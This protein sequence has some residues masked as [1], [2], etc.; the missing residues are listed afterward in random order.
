[1]AKAAAAPSK[2]Q[3][4]K[5]N[6]LTN[7]DQIISMAEK[8][9]LNLPPAAALMELESHG[10]NVYGNDTGGALAGFPGAVNKGNFEVYEWMV[11]DLGHPANGVGPSQITSL[12]LLTEMEEEGLRPYNVADNMLFGFT[13]L[14]GYHKATGTWRKAGT[15]YN[16]STAYGDR[17]AEAVAR[18][19]KLLADAA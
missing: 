19:R 18:W 6:G 4:L 13:L 16:G 9:G 10:R 12:G 3:V 11:R 8:A 17:F 5:D 15:R 7:V 1:M 14:L 2:A